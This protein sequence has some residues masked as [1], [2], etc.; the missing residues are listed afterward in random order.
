M[1]AQPRISEFAL[2]RR[3][4][5]K[6]SLGIGVGLG[7]TSLLTSCAAPRSDAAELNW[8][9][10]T[11]YLDYD[12]ESGTFPT[13]EEF[14]AAS[15]IAVNYFEDI[16]DNNTFNAVVKDQLQLEQD[17]GYDT[18]VVS[19]WL[20][21][22]WH[23]AGQ[24]QALDH[25]RMPNLANLKPAW[26][27][28]S[29]DPERS[30]SVPW[31]GFMT[32]IAVRKEYAKHVRTLDDLLNPIFEGRVGM[33]TEMRDTAGLIMLQQGV[34]IESSD[35]GDAEFENAMTWLS[36]NLSNGKISAVKGGSFVQDLVSGA[37]IATLAWGGEIDVLNAEHGDQWEFIVPESGGNTDVTSFTVPNGSERVREVEQLIDYYYDPEIAARVAATVGYITPVEGA[38]EAMER[39]DPAL[40]DNPL[41]FPDAEL[42]ARLKVFRALSSSEESRYAQ[43][44]ARVLGT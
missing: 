29:F 9:N 20:I 38:R 33:L 5:L 11:Y 23:A 18:V 12:P 25:A 32:G 4:L 28:P 2:S 34:D 14:T 21:A 26:A 36:R 16:D 40:V 1:T 30:Y 27:S 8:G 22:R 41:I 39:V 31:Q 17:I 24:V 6:Y 42:Q 43:Q 37:S 35:W 13:L 15:G 19:D 7:A 3:S 10:W 44:F